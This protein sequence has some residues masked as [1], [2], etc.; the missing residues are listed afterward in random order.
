MNVTLTNIR[1]TSIA[2][3][4]ILRTSLREDATVGT[5]LCRFSETRNVARSALKTNIAK[6][7]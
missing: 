1:A 6:T 2:T 7:R 4:R 3:A 5:H